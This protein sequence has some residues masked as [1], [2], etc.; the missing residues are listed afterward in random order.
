MDTASQPSYALDIDDVDAD[1]DNTSNS[2]YNGIAN[3]NTFCD[4]DAIC[5][6]SIF[7]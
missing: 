1:D 7:S 3:N 2:Y 6:T 4:T 5:N